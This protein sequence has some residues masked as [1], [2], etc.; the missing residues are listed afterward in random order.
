MEHQC[1]VTSHCRVF[2]FV[3]DT[4]LAS[5]VFFQHIDSIVSSFVSQFS[6]CLEDCFCH[7]PQPTVQGSVP[8]TQQVQQ[9]IVV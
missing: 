2:A 9:E 1:A 6:T 4:T 7:H 8:T 5:P 3:V